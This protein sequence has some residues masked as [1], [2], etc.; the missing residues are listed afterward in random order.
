[1]A[2]TSEV[3][4]DGKVLT[5]SQMNNIIAGIDEL[6]DSISLESVLKIVELPKQQN[7]DLFVFGGQSNMMGAPYLPP[8]ENPV[9]YYA[10][11]YKYQN[12][13]KG[14]SKGEFIYAQNPAGEWHYKN[15]STA[16]NATYLDAAT[17]KSK[18]TNYGSNTHFIGALRNKEAE[19]AAQSEFSNYPGASLPP[20][21][22]REYAKLGNPCIYAHMAKGSTQLTHYF[23]TE[24]NAQ[25]NGLITAHNAAN[26]TSYA[27]L[28]SVTG[29]GEAFNEKYNAML[30]DYAE[31]EPDN[32][33]AN[34]CFVWLQGESDAARSTYDEYMIKM[35]VLWSHMQKLGFTHFFVMRVGYWGNANIINIIKAQEDF[36]RNNDNCYIV[37]R[38]PSLIPYP[39]ATTSNWWIK[40]PDEIYAGCRDSLVTS[41]T[42]NHFNEKGHK[43]FAQVCA[44]NINRVLHL[45]LEPILE[46]EN[47]KGMTSNPEDGGN[48]GGN[49][50]TE[51]TETY[52]SYKGASDFTTPM[53]ITRNSESDAWV[54]VT[55]GTSAQATDFIEVT[56]KDSVWIQ[57]VYTRDNLNAVGGFYDSEKNLIAAMYVEN[58]GLDIVGGTSGT[59]AF[60]TPEIS[61]R[62]RIDEVENVT[63]KIV[64]YVKFVAWPASAGGVDNTEARVYRYN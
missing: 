9:T 60:A 32:T 23:D 22:A 50:G 2:Y 43:L 13:L 56:S 40:E 48:T 64:K 46:T 47:I 36:C 39:G 59:A 20:Y 41:T 15:P 63:S 10:F 45:G 26:G 12:V 4:S 35:K 49:G 28:T 51:T 52:V 3:F 42:N 24:D 33:I 53:K 55:E 54:E 14:G 34:K 8:V 37:T 25:Y 44:A 38:A 58:F 11:E 57:Y 30:R 21:F 1:M 29:A 16:Y 18:L 17:G 19:F 6:K 61:N 7:I 5:A 31:L 62:I 27:T